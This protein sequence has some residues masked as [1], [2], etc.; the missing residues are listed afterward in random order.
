MRITTTEEETYH[1]L[2]LDIKLP[3]GWVEHFSC[4]LEELDGLVSEF[5]SSGRKTESLESSFNEFCIHS[6]HFLDSIRKAT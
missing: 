2:T 1:P 3:Q 6:E 4:L 5:H